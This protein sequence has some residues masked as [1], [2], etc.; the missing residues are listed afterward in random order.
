MTTIMNLYGQ[1][2]LLINTL[3]LIGLVVVGVTISVLDQT[4]RRITSALRRTWALIGLALILLMTLSPFKK[5]LGVG[6]ESIQISHAISPLTQPQASGF[7]WPDWHDPIGNILMTIPL[8]TALALTWTK[9]RTILTIFG[10]SAVIEITQYFYRHG[11][12]AQ[13]SDVLLNTIGGV[14]GVGIATLSLLIASKIG[15]RTKETGTDSASNF[16]D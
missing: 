14:C 7:H 9:R 12:T 4:H 11:R 15:T 16:A 1:H 13:A 6:F 3:V 8:A 5:G 10:L 2:G